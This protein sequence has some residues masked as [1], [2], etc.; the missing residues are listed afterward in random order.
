MYYTFE[1]KMCSAYET[2]EKQNRY[3]LP[4]ISKTC[5]SKEKGACKDVL[6]IS[7]APR[8]SFRGNCLGATVP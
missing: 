7:E 8:N 6:G 5:P 4:L 2:N 3:V 1:L